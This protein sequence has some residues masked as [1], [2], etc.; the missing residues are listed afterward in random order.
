[1]SASGSRDPSR[2]SDAAVTPG[3]GLP[4]SDR[5]AVRPPLAYLIT[6]T[7]FGTWLHGDPRGSADR[8]H[9]IPGTPYLDPNP[10]RAGWERRRARQ[11]SVTLDSVARSVVKAAVVE[12][13]G[14]RD[15]SLHALNVRT[16]HV[17]AVVSA[18]VR[19]ELIL[20]DL[21][22]YATRA[23]RRAR[24]AG[25]GNTPWTRGGS[26][27]YLWKTESVRAACRYVEEGQGPDL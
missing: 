18:P 8:D 9:N 5:G 12:V 22:A 4:G 27:R 11:S 2:R 7:T 21:K 15:W 13:C 17:H 10:R 26:T 6:F 20:H 23:L 24:R 14:Y 25:A 16:N 1:M 3:G 19:P